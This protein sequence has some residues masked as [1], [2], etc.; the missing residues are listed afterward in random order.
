M[1]MVGKFFCLDLSGGEKRG[2]RKAEQ[3][4]IFKR[5]NFTGRGGEENEL[6]ALKS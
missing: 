2:E 5:V 6:I 1:R 4:N 3:G